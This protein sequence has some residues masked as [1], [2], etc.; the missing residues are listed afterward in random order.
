MNTLPHSLGS[1]NP[2][3]H[4]ALNGHCLLTLSTSALE[5]KRTFLISSGFL[6]LDL[7]APRFFIRDGL[8]RDS[9]VDLSL[10]LRET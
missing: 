10:R 2:L 9:P 3:P 6:L 8:R 5:Q 1:T 4:L 7:H